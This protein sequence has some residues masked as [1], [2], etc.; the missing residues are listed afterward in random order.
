[1]RAQRFLALSFAAALAALTAWTTFDPVSTERPG[2][3][4]SRPGWPRRGPGGAPGGGRGRGAPPPILGPPAGVEPLPIDLFTSKNF[5]KDRANWL[6]KRYYRCNTPRQLYG[7]WDQ[8]PHRPQAARVGVVGRLQRRLDARADRQPVPLQDGEG[9]LRGADGRRPRP[10]AARPSTPRRRC[11]TG[12]ATTARR[13]ADRGSEWIWGVTQAP[14]VLSLLT[15]EVSEADGADHLPRGGD[16]RAAVERLVLLA[17]RIHPLVG[18]AVA[19]GQLPADD[20][21]RGTSSSCRASPT[22]SCA[23]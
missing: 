10:R 4:S 6:D 23:R 12:T 18:A 8:Q 13:H 22:T 1:M 3:G 16:Q 9:T 11:P 21:A 7:M 19:G 2:A 15:P 17:R 5:Y 14:T 20:D